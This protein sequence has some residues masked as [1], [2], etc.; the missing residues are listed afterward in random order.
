MTQETVKHGRS[1]SGRAGG[2][3]DLSQ[4]SLSQP[5][6]LIPN[7]ECVSCGQPLTIPAAQLADEPDGFNCAGCYFVGAPQ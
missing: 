5:R 2:P 7:A 6:A 4:S 3:S 1:P